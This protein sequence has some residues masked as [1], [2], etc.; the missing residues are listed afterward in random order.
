MVLWHD[1]M[2]LPMGSAIQ[3]DTALSQFEPV[4]HG[5]C[6]G[7]RSAARN[8]PEQPRQQIKELTRCGKTLLTLRPEPK[9][10]F[11]FE[12]VLRRVMKWKI[13]PS[14]KNK[15]GPDPTEN[16]SRGSIRHL[17]HRDA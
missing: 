15:R 8:P 4:A 12:F 6:T 11:G 17:S 7:V 9:G 16:K 13:C 3:S 2:A 5:V 14:Q 10:L 1:E